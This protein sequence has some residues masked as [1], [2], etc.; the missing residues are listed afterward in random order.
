[1]ERRALY[2]DVD[3]GRRPNGAVRLE[4]EDRAVPPSILGH[5]RERELERPP[6]RLGVDR[7]RTRRRRG[8]GLGGSA[9]PLGC[10]RPR[11]AGDRKREH[12][13]TGHGCLAGGVCQLE[14]DGTFHA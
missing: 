10:K 8:C 13:L 2:T 4:N 5:R 1:M 7:Q 9:Q 11:T 14:P 3:S 12:H 6:L